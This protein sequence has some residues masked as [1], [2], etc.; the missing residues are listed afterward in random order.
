MSSKVVYST[1]PRDTQSLGDHSPFLLH[2]G[3]FQSVRPIVG[4]LMMNVDITTGVMFKGGPLIDI[5]MM[6]LGVNNI[7]DLQG[8]QRRDILRRFLKNLTFKMTQPLRGGKEKVYRITD[9]SQPASEIRFLNQE[10][11]EITVVV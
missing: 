1:I 7:R 2:R 5:C 8:Q 4:H 9:I 3:F 11:E 6:I 10:G